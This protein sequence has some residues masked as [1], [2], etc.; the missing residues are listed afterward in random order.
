MTPEEAAALRTEVLAAL[1]AADSGVDVLAALW[2]AV[3]GKGDPPDPEGLAK[4]WP[5]CPEDARIEAVDRCVRPLA[6]ALVQ[7]G[8]DGYGVELFRLWDPLWTGEAPED[9]DSLTLAITRAWCAVRDAPRP[10]T[11]PGNQRVSPE[12]PR[13]IPHPLGPIVRAWADRPRDLSR[14]HLIVTEERHPPKGMGSLKLARTPG[15]LALTGATL[16]AVQVDGEAFAT[17]QPDMV[18][19]RQWQVPPIKQGELF[20]GPRNMDGRATAGLIVEAVA[21][22]DIDGRSPL[23]ADT[24]KLGHLAYALTG[25]VRLTDAEG[26]A[27]TGGQDTPAN[28]D[29]FHRAMW[30]LRYMRAKVRPRRWAALVDAEPGDGVNRLGPPRWWL[31]KKKPRAYKLTGSLFRRQLLPAPGARGFAIGHLGALERTIAGLEGALLWGT[32][33]AG[34]G[35]R[36]RAPDNLRPVRKG[37]P[38]PKVFVRWWQVLRLSGEPVGPDTAAQS[39]AGRRYRRRVAMLDAAGYMVPGPTATAGDTIEVVKV[40]RGGRGKAAG[41]VIRATAR[42]CAAYGDGERVRIPAGQLIE[43]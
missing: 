32:P 40:Q 28:R 2:R 24:L 22:L 11:P 35:R 4:W 8:V 42:F 25:A 12:S 16:E 27:L 13:P 3:D 9:L 31:D 7:A 21:F 5:E 41:I 20:S 18:T 23:R 26:A 19:V 33:S 29:R 10:D 38:G 1:E 15:L 36:G 14:R 17:H 30:A 39:A 6:G 34:K 43:A 37:G